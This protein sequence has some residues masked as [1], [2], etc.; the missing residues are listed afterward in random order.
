MNKKT[1]TLLFL[2]CFAF[3][4]ISYRAI[5]GTAVTWNGTTYT[6]P[7]V[8]D[9]NWGE[10]VGN[11]LISLVNNG[12][13]KTGGTF[14]LSSEADLGG[15]AGLVALYFGTRSSSDSTTGVFRLS[16][17]ES[18]GW[19]NAANSADLLLTVSTNNSLLFNGAT[20]LNSSN[21]V[22][23]TSGGTG[24]SSYAVGDLLYA[25]GD[26][27]VL[28]KLTIGTSG[29]VLK[30]NGSLPSWGQITNSGV[31]TSAAI[32]R[33][34]LASGNN[35]RI[36]ANDSSGV[37]SENAALTA[38]RPVISDTNGQLTTEA[39]LAVSRGG[40]NIGSYTTGDLLYVSTNSAVL[41]KLAIGSTGN[42]LKVA[43]GL[44]SW[45]SAA[46]T[47]A[48]SS[49]KTS[50]YTVTSNDDVL[51]VSPTSGTVILSLP[52]ASANSGK[53]YHV[54]RV[55]IGSQ[56]AR[57]SA[58]SGDTIDESATFLLPTRSDA[59]SI[60][61]DG[62]NTWRVFN[63][64]VAVSVYCTGAASTLI[65]TSTYTLRDYSSCTN[66][67]HS[68][69]TTGAGWKFTAPKA[70]YYQVSVMD[71]FAPDGTGGFREIALYKNGTRNSSICQTSFT[72]TAGKAD[73]CSGS[74]SIY[75]ERNDRISIYIWQNSGGDE[76]LYNDAAFQWI[77][78][79][80]I[81]N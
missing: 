35:Y 31:D 78:I 14:T 66:D 36:V 8:G 6:V 26:P 79:S 11:L 16:N 38:D 15:T 62:S 75:L 71:G 70:G 30:S 34:K 29:Y 42:I 39:T 59:V 54:E 80:K 53:V 43:G 65:S 25:S 67:T 41:S 20:I 28:S 56:I 69:V 64:D 51:L 47:A 52:L 32:A 48:V 81:G 2:S 63:D 27:S 1:F 46:T 45:G 76:A 18:I 21:L 72:G 22:P 37:M 33:T 12:F 68:A 13:Q 7:A 40:T 55:A 5:S 74:R 19:R 49:V 73:V 9:E 10:D 44:P 4:F 57:V 58:A 17:A 61:S 23:V 50:D 3:L 77:S 60:V 24:L